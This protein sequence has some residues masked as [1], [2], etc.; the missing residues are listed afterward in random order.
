MQFGFVNQTKLSVFLVL[1]GRKPLECF[2]FLMSEN[3]KTN[4]KN[5]KFLVTKLVAVL[6]QNISWQGK[7]L[8]LQSG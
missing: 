4:R 6:F 3:Y 1:E 8:Y 7:S 5:V 2:V